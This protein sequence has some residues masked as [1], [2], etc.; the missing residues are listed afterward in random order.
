M[1]QA[2]LGSLP[3]S[4]FC[5]FII[6][7]RGCLPEE[8]RLLPCRAEPHADQ[9]SSCRLQITAMI[10][11]LCG[12]LFFGILIGSLGE[13]VSTASHNARRAQLFR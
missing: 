3:L 7:A 6:T 8:E 12:V 5:P 9:D 10:I 2:A 1:G 4:C 11:M 13:I